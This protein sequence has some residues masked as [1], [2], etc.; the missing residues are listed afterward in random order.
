M[1]IYKGA[2]IYETYN[3][4]YNIKKFVIYILIYNLLKFFLSYIG[5]PDKE[6]GTIF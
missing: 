1:K 5:P 2:Y 4:L 3:L 6:N